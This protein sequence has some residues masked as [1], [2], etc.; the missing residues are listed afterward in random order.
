MTAGRSRTRSVLPVPALVFFALL[1]MSPELLHAHRS[2]A[3]G[4]YNAECPLAEIAARHSDASL[5][6]ELPIVPIGPSV[7]TV[8]TVGPDNAAS[9]SVR[10]ADPRAPPLA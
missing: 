2:G 3:V 6:S 5:P 1:L 9:S 8:P 7:E 10:F 4:L